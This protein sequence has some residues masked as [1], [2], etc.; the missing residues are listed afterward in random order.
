MPPA[1]AA[2]RRS[3]VRPASSTVAATRRPSNETRAERFGRFVGVAVPWVVGVWMVLITLDAITGDALAPWVAALAL[4]VAAAVVLHWRRSRSPRSVIASLAIAVPYHVLVPE[5]VIPVPA[6]I[7]LWS[8]T[9]ARPPR[10]SLFGLAALLAVC[11]MNLFTTTVDDTLFTAALIVIVWALAEVVRSRRAAIVQ[12]ADRAVRLEQD[13]IAR[14]LHDVIAHSVTVMVVQAGAADEVFTSRPDDARAA[15]RS[16]AEVGRATLSELRRLLNVVRPTND[17]PSAPQPGLAH[18][19]ELAAVARRAGLDITVTAR[20]AERPTAWRRRVRLPHRAGSPDQHVAP[21]QRQPCRRDAALRRRRR[22]HLG[23]RRRPGN[24]RTIAGR[25]RPGA[26]RDARAGGDARR[27]RRDRADCAGRLRVRARLPL[28]TS[29][30]DG[31]GP[32]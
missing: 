21:R 5:A 16:I 24:R 9:L 4:A 18:V 29:T 7:A 13:R 6:M 10:I 32:K 12:N 17:A 31:V 14:E 3:T 27:D 11:S 25:S 1:T 2:R 8:L 28:D 22:R 23:R 15:L 19:D 20:P 26:R 30:A